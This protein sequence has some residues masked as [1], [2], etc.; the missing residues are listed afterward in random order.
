[1]LDIGAILQTVCLLA[2]AR[3]L[4]SCILAASVS[5]PALIREIIPIPET[6]A[7][8]IGVALGYPDEG[9][10]DQPFHKGKGEPGRI[11]PLGQVNVKA[12]NSHTPQICTQNI[13]DAEISYLLYEGDGPPLIFLHAT[14]FLP[15]LWHPLARELAGSYRIFAPSFCDHRETDPENGGLNWITL[16]E[17][18]SRLCDACIWRN[19]FWSAIPWGRRCT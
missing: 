12:E 3:G 8:I 7:V 5:Y 10:A 6:K 9:G 15:W 1:M 18:L 11:H 14:G 13:G 19:P 2:H 16:A 4:G 17:D